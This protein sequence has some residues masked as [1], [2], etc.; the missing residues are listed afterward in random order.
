M[1]FFYALFTIVLFTVAYFDIRWRRIPNYF[2][3]PLLLLGLLAHTLSAGGI[4]ASKSLLG[5]MVGGGLFAT[6][7]FLKMMGAGDVKL[8]AAVGAWLGSQRIIYAL[9]YIIVAGGL[10]AI[11]Q[12]L[13]Y[14]FRVTGEQK[15]Q[16]EETMTEENR[17]DRRKESLQM[18]LPYGVAIVIGT[19]IALYR[20]F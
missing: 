20:F 12:L 6:L 17:H 11:G 16:Q 5:M 13:H 4:G 8:M 1:Y 19:L 3:L 2:S 15:I 18:T 10:L 9:F 7:Y 14:R